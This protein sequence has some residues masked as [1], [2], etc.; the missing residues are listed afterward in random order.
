MSD[1][2]L[3]LTPVQ[4]TELRRLSRMRLLLGGLGTCLLVTLGLLLGRLEGLVRLAHGGLPVGMI[5]LG[6]GLFAWDAR[7]DPFTLLWDGVC[8]AA[9]GAG[10]RTERRTITACGVRRMGWDHVLVADDGAHYPL[11]ARIHAVPYGTAITI[12]YS[13]R[14]RRVWAVAMEGGA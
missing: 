13:P 1:A 7:L 2:T 10:R 9:D 11:S 8:G 12:T 4:A 6:R 3:R 14:T 5:I